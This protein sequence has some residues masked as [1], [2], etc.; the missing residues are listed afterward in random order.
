MKQTMLLFLTLAGVT[1]VSAFCAEELNQTSD[2][3]LAEARPCHKSTEERD[4][5][6][7]LR[8]IYKAL[9]NYRRDRNDSLPN[10]LRDLTRRWILDKEILIC[11]SVR[12]RGGLRAW[13]KIVNEQAADPYTSYAYEFSGKNIQTLLWRGFPL[14]TYREFKERQI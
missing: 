9:Q 13:G 1:L 6:A 10:E 8:F 4:C 7:N 5:E 2:P 3:I 12:R 14:K 11:P